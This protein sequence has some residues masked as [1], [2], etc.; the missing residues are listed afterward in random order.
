MHYSSRRVPAVLALCAVAAACSSSKGTAPAPTGSMTVTV[1]T[2]NRATPSVV[3]SGP[4]GY[5]KTITSTQTI[6]G[7]A[8]GNYV[9]V[10]DSAVTPDSVVGSIID[11]GVVTGSPAT[12]AANATAAASAT[13]AMKYRIGGL[14]VANNDAAT[15]PDLS[16]NQLR[17][18]GTITPAADPC[19]TSQGAG[20]T[21]DQ[22]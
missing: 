20:R 2:A 17:A 4:N 22:C 14:W 5:T 8:V 12:V 19:H 3:I 13:Y 15:M 6:T 7:L 21:C 11:T 18:G 9:I 10:A 1:T 16:A